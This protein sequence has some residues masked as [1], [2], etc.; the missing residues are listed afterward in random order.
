MTNV[1]GLVDLILYREAFLFGTISF[2]WRGTCSM[3]LRAK[4]GA[5]FIR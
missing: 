3:K 2:P 5:D 1:G 4:M